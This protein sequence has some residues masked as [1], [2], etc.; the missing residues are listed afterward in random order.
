LAHENGIQVTAYSPFGPLSFRE[1]EWTK[2]KDA[3][4]LFEHEVIKKIAESH[5]KTPAQVLL[6]WSIQRGLAVIPTSNDPQRLRQNLD[7]NSFDL[8]E[9][10]VGKISA[11]DKGLRFNDPSDPDCLKN[12]IRIFA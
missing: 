10:E 7:C 3:P 5:G 1:L 6:R 4:P 2:A 8:S 9:T 11:L 12:P